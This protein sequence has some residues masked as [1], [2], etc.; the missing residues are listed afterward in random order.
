VFNFLKSTE[1]LEHDLRQW[2]VQGWV[3]T[4]GESQRHEGEEYVFSLAIKQL[5]QEVAE[6][7]YSS[8][9][10]AKMLRKMEGTISNIGDQFFFLRGIKLVQDLAKRKGWKVMMNGSP[11][12]GYQ[13]EIC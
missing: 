9:Q 7:S 3:L 10:H 1:R 2:A 12:S 5:A 13:C 8:V 4:Q 11:A 6:K